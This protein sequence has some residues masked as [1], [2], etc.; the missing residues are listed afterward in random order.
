M[1][2]FR[3]LHHL[4]NTGPTPE[5]PA[6]ALPEPACP[7]IQPCPEL[8]CPA[9]VC[10]AAP[11]VCPVPEQQQWVDPRLL[12]LGSSLLGHVAWAFGRWIVGLCYGGRRRGPAPPRRG[13]G[14][15]E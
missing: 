9:V 8:A 6:I 2:A 12:G 11:C 15:V 7:A 10:E 4:A 5:C 1:E 14:I 3:T 13:G